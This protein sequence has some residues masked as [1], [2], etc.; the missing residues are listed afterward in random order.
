MNDSNPNLGRL[1]VHTI[2]NKMRDEPLTFSDQIQNVPA[3]LSKTILCSYLRQLQIKEESYN[4]A[5]ETSAFLHIKSLFGSSAKKFQKLSESLA[6]LLYENNKDISTSKI[7]FLVIDL[8]CEWK[9]EIKNCIILIGLDRF[10][11]TLSTSEYDHGVLIS[12]VLAST[13]DK[14]SKIA[15]FVENE[16]SFYSIHE[17]SHNRMWL[18]DFLS[19]SP[20]PNE[21]NKLRYSENL[22]R[23]VSRKIENSKKNQKFKNDIYDLLAN[24]DNVAL[25]ELSDCC[26]KFIDEGI[27][28]NIDKKIKSSTRLSIEPKSIISTDILQKKVKRF[29]KSLQ[30]MKGLSITVSGSREVEII[31][32]VN[33]SENNTCMIKVKLK[34]E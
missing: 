2:G 19:A 8:N 23:Q 27:Y 4:I 14:L 9:G 34:E 26:K 11:Q 6:N 17:N 15:L 22:I 10:E 16:N 13:P 33:S 32:E 5:V 1:I 12:S 24:S 31:E 7:L 20:T 21:S 3:D 29:M 30:V 25:E 28:D 18:F